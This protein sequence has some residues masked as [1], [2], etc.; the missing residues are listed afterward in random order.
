VTPGQ[1]R[2][3]WL[4]RRALEERAAQDRA[5]ALRL[6]YDAIAA[7]WD[8]RPFVGQDG[9]AWKESARAHLAAKAGRQE[10]S[11]VRPVNANVRRT[12]DG[13]LPKK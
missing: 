8:A 13:R 5:E 7:G 2:T 1:A 6:H 4:E 12:R 3:V 11:P 9:D 10:K